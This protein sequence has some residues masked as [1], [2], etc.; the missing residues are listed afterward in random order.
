MTHHG[1][2]ITVLA[3]AL[4]ACATAASSMDLLQAYEAARTNDATIL[5]SRAN[6]QAVQERLPQAR[7]Q[8][9]PNVA[10]SASRNQNHLVQT[11]PNLLGKEQT[12]D[13]R[14]PSSNNTLTL[15]QPLFRTQQMAQ[16]RQAKAQVD[17]AEATLG[18]DEQNLAV[19]VTG[20]YFEALLTHEQLE[21]V[22]SQSA[23]YTTQLDAARKSLAGGSGTRTDIDEA[24][25]RLDINAA[26][27]IEAR[28]NIDYTMR[29]LRVLVNQ[30][31]DRLATL[32]LSKFE[33]LEPQP[34][35][36]ED[37]YDRAGQNSPQL[38]SLKAQ[39][40]VSRQEVEKARSGHY[41]T[42]DAIAQWSRSD[43]E[44]ILNTNSSYTN[45]VLGVQL[46]VPIF[47]GGYVNSQV[48]QALAG[49][50]SAKQAL[51]AGRRDLEM[52]VYKE[53]RG[54]ADNIPKIRALEQALRSADQSV[55]SSKKSFLGGSRTVVDI[56]DAEQRRVLV[57]RDLAQTRYLYLISKIRLLALVGS[58]DAVAIAAINQSLQN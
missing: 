22:L 16:Y 24:Q 21:L 42:L 10:F 35:R 13:T 19:R 14:Y 55:L 2:K 27:E 56:M 51:E 11:V 34:N 33:L 18:Q 38:A 52:R 30:P 45:R 49:L 26:L 43:S 58:A 36:V 47:A 48:R 57:L 20:A 17:D 54:V 37:W 1:L 40:E 32:D 53:F 12:T 28:R 3:G 25:A 39:V 50:E 5:E 9:F 4:M 7:A 23:A 44:N 8:F 15:R 31:I 29:Q 46:N 41:P 6:A